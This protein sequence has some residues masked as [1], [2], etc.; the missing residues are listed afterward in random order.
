LSKGKSRRIRLENGS[1]ILWAPA[2]EAKWRDVLSKDVVDV[3][4]EFWKM[5]QRLVQNKRAS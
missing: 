4:V 3:V 5:K 1:N 2:A